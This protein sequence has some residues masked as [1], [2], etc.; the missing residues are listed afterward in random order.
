MVTV[1]SSNMLWF[2]YAR[3]IVIK[4][5]SLLILPKSISLGI[6]TS[7]GSVLLLENAGV[8]S[9]RIIKNAAN[10]AAHIITVLGI[11][12]FFFSCV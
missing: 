5:C 11:F 2:S 10:A 6:S 4:T 8:T 1:S 9:Q 7:P 3:V 12:F